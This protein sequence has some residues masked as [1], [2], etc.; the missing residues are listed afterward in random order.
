MFIEK[1]PLQ[2]KYIKDGNRE[3]CAKST[4]CVTATKFYVL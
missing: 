4:I 2:N 3:D 1:I